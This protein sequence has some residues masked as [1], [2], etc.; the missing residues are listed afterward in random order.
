LAAVL[1]LSSWLTM[2][3]ST[4]PERPIDD[5]RELL[6]MPP[7]LIMP[8]ESWPIVPIAPPVVPPIVPVDEPVPVVPVPVVGG[9]VCAWRVVAAA[10]AA[11]VAN[12]V[13]VRNIGDP[14]I[15]KWRAGGVR[16]SGPA[17]RSGT[18]AR[19]GRAFP[20]GARRSAGPGRRPVN[21]RANTSP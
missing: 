16:E 18:T 8:A 4:W 1:T 14:R 9:V 19:R 12:S 20:P 15:D 17:G 3:E 11:A 21:A 7:R 10:S 5:R 6:R 2:V 13:T